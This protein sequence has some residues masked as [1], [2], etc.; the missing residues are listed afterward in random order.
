MFTVETLE[1]LVELATLDQ[2]LYVRFSEGPE[3]DAAEVSVDHESG[4]RLPG[5]SVNPLGAESWWDRPA[6]HWVAR[7]LRQYAHL[8][9]QG[10]YAW[11]LTGEV[12]GRGPDCEPLLV[13]VKPVA[14]LADQ[15]IDEAAQLYRRV[16]DAGQDGT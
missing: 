2:R 6:D 9:V 11:V 10:R 8:A 1:E 12:V 13:D 7:Q 5:L 14:R 16:F 4:C 3:A 15:V